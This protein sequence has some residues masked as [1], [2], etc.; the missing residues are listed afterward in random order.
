MR[1]YVY[2][3][4]G[5]QVLHSTLPR[6][7]IEYIGSTQAG[8]GSNMAKGRRYLKSALGC[9]GRAV[10]RTINVYIKIVENDFQT[11]GLDVYY[12]HIEKCVDIIMEIIRFIKQHS[13]DQ[14]KIE[15][16][17]HIPTSDDE[18]LQLLY[19]HRISQLKWVENQDYYGQAEKATN[20]IDRIPIQNP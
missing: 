14:K 5:P 6:K 12:Y 13:N 11:Y 2:A 7:C 9:S 16:F 8:Y 1:D 3:P 19:G 10:K 15:L 17:G 18:Y 20:I 4:A